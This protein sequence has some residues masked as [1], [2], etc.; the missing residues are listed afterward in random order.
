M[1][2]AVLF[3]LEETL[4]QTPWAHHKHVTEFRWKTKERLTKLGIPPSVLEGIERA[5]IMRN[6]ASEY[7]EKNLTRASSDRIQREM[8]RFLSRYE[9]DS[10][11][12]SKLF[13]ETIT[14]LQYL[15]KRGVKMGLVTNTSMRA[16]DTVFRLHGLNSYFD[17]VMTREK[18]KK[19]KPDPEGIVLAAER[20]GAKNLFM[21]GD[22]VHDA[23]AAERAKVTSIIVKRNPEEKLDFRADYVVHSLTQ[24]PV[25]VEAETERT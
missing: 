19:L 4:V 7:V 17:V 2:V 18:V 6:K 14:T 11:R 23:L 8:E 9:L 10:A 12:R 16:V 13:P 25:I 21:V 20:L 5:T 1:A 24:V 15:K 22:L 3:D